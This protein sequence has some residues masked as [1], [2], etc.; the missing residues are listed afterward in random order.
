MKIL[1]K[2][3]GTLLDT[4]DSR[5]RLAGEIAALAAA[6]HQVVVV[7]GGGKQMTRFLAERKVESR[8][9]NGLRVTSPEVVDALLKVLGGTVNH[10]LVAAFVQAG[11]RPVGL[12]GLDAGTAVAEQLNPELGAV[13]R[14]TGSDGRLMS[15]LAA[16]GYLP[17]VACIGGDANGA[18]YNVNADQM[19]VAC[20]GG[21]GADALFFLTDV[22]G[23]RIADGSTAAAL[24]P[25][26]IAGL[27]AAGVATGGM[28]A[29]LEAATRA[30]ESGVGRVIVAPGQLPGLVGRLAAG[31]RVGTL[32]TAEGA[33][34]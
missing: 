12:S 5:A 3:G 29:K 18:I 4:P 19:A 32:I 20:A 17:V 6:G 26:A 34:A 9:V 8:F 2:L 10:E 31:E 25:G 1:V 23:V 22:D 14:P 27:I 11:A 15:L 16:N 30:L 13:G 21:F 28:Q 24:T 7:H 33:H